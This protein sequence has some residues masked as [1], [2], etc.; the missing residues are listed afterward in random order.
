MDSLLLEIQNGKG[1]LR[2]STIIGNNL[3]YAAGLLMKS[4]KKI[5]LEKRV[6]KW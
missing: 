3:T 5:L 6:K 4:M 1:K 2:P